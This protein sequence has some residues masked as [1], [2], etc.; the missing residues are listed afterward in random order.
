MTGPLSSLL[1]TALVALLAFLTEGLGALLLSP[2]A[3][4]LCLRNALVEPVLV[5]PASQSKGPR[6]SGAQLI[7]LR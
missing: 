5:R 7:T 4:R 6:R 3:N 2:E 1:T